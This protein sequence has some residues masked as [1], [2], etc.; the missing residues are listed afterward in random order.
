M[1]AA[2]LTAGSAAELRA[3]GTDLSERRRSGVSAGPLMDLT[4]S[5]GMTAIAWG[6][7]GAA[8]IGA[9]MTMAAI[10]R[11]AQIAAAYPG[12]AAAAGGLATPQVRQL[13]TIGGNLA[14]H[15]RCWYYRHPHLSCLKKGGA[16]CPARRGNH[17]YGVA[18]DLGPCVA[19]HP[20]TMAA[21]LL[22]YDAVVATDRQRALSIPQ[23]LGDGSVGKAD[24]MLEPGEVIESIALPPPLAG[25]RALYRRAIGRSQAEWPL[26]EIVA[27]AAISGGSFRVL[28]LA[29]GG[30]A[31]VPLRL[32]AAEAAGQGAAASAATI[33]MIA[34][35]AIAGARPLPMTGYKLDLMKGLVRDLLE[36]LVA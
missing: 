27:R 21:A 19:P 26:V 2:T 23:L 9:A 3:G 7:D 16:D 18:F 24:N 20:S 1:S 4:P 31:P 11:D 17:L 28:R 29:A 22:A 35:Q 25:E 30:V 33:A 8:R 32:S 5:A 10:A 6:G 36:R 15:S 34:E 14:Q 13:A 12:L